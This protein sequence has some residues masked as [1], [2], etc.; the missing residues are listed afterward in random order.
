[1]K[2]FTIP[3]Y[4]THIEL[5]VIICDDRQEVADKMAELYK[6]CP[7]SYYYDMLSPSM[8]CI[9]ET[10]PMDRILMILQPNTSPST[11]AHEAVHVTHKLSK[12]VGK[13]FSSKVEEPQAYLVGYITSKILE[14]VTN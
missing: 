3:L 4:P 14:N 12:M 8:T 13:F 7:S 6:G 9:I 1:M 5:D 11:I 10:L 2:Y